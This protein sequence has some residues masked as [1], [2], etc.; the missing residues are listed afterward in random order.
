MP[1]P[2]KILYPYF[3]VFSLILINM[4]LLTGPPDS[5]LPGLFSI[6]TSTQFLTTDA[7]AVGGLNSAFLNAGILGFYVVLV[8]KLAKVIPSGA[9]I[10]AFFLTIGFSFFG[11]NIIN[12]WPIIFGVWLYSRLKGEPFRQYVHF[13]F[14][15]SALAP[16]VS[17]MIFP[18]LF[19]I[20]PQLGIPLSIVVGA[21]LGFLIPSVSALTATMHKGFN[22]FNVGLSG[23]FLGFAFFAIYKTFVLGPLGLA[24]DFRLNSILSEGFPVF[25]P[26]FLFLVFVLTIVTGFIL[27]RNSF[28]NYKE[29]FLNSGLKADFTVLYGAAVALINVG[30][31]GLLFLAYFYIVK[32]P[33]NGPAIG[34]LFSIVSMAGLGSH[35][36]NTLPI[37]GGYLVTSLF[38]PWSP[39]TLGIA[40]GLCFATGMSP[41]SGRWGY[42][43][44]LIAGVI[45]AAFVTSTAAFHGGFN[46]YN[47][48]FTSGLVAIVLIPVLEAFSRASQSPN[49]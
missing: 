24:D 13:G 25:L 1:N 39:G 23:G 11:K 46:I 20:T 29:L 49:R 45:H 8:L 28:K 16:I 41:I 22:L 17:E 14:F 35:P 31:L 7:F 21:L 38:A 3:I 48:G 18:R 33:F 12:M 40:V 43:W 34:G 2:G 19:S 32:A 42:H 9:S 27:N 5:L 4:S 47:G 30:L 44:G 36:R 6:A 37:M 15:G 26:V 10:A